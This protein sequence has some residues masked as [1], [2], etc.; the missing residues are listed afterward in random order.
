MVDIT[1]IFG[2]IKA[3]F[4]FGSKLIDF[5]ST[6]GGQKLIDQTLADR[7][8]WDS[9]WSDTGTKLE[10]FFKSIGSIKL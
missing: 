10:N 8:K 5:Y 6:P 4:E 7:A 2:A 9:F 1:L 3:G